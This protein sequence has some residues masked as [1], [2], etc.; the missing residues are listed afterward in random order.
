[1]HDPATAID[2]ENG[3]LKWQEQAESD[4]GEPMEQL[5]GQACA[6][7][8]HE[9]QAEVMLQHSVASLANCLPKSMLSEMP[10]S[11]G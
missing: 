5:G 3:P 10:R 4:H 2:L 9:L 8:A 1:M 11:S 6:H 7:K